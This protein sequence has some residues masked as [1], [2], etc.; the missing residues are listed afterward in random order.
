MSDRQ[1]YVEAFN[2]YR[3][4]SGRSKTPISELSGLSTRIRHCFIDEGID[5]IERLLELSDFEL[6]RIPNFGRKS[7]NEVQEAI[8]AY[9]KANDVLGFRPQ[10]YA[11][12]L[13]AIAAH[14]QAAATLL[15]AMVHYP[16]P[17]GNGAAKPS[18]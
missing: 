13:R 4:A 16:Q 10:Q 1:E 2:A 9:L 5:T 18:E 11:Q 17:R 6:R 3:A 12:Q 7:F 8:G 14:L 15:D